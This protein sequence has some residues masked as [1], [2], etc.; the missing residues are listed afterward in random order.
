MPR[1]KTMASIE[2]RIKQAEDAVVKAKGKYDGALSRLEA[3]MKE[4][5][6]IQDLEMVALFKK[7]GKS[8]DAVKRYLND[9]S[10]S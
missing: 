10:R 3:L 1:Q 8:F 5:E 9:S 4:K 7:S 2:T 6:H